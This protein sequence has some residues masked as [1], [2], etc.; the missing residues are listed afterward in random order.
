MKQIQPKTNSQA[1]PLLLQI[2]HHTILCSLLSGDTPGKVY[3][4]QPGRPSVAFGQFK[5]RAYLSGT[6]DT[7]LKAFLREFF[8]NTVTQ[9]CREA[10]V[11][12]FRLTVNDP[13]WLEIVT[14]AL[15]DLK[16][17]PVDYR[18]YRIDLDQ[19][20][21]SFTVPEGFELRETDQNLVI[22][23]FP[24]RDD[25][26]EEMCSERESVESFLAHSFGIVA[27]KEGELAGWCLSEYNHGD[28]CEVGIATM[29]PFQRLGLA[30]AMTGAFLQLAQRRGIKTVLWQCYTSNLP[31]WK[32]ALSAGF[33]LYVEDQVL[34]LYIVPE[35]NLAVHGNLELRAGNYAKALEWYHKALSGEH[36]EDWM[37]LNAARAAAQ[38][39]MTDLA[40]GFLEQAFDLG[41]DDRE[42]LM[43]NSLLAKLR[44]SPKWEDFLAKLP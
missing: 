24:G 11:P 36:H 33:H 44:T 23:D 22:S 12:F 13:R 5:H 37:P 3:L 19:P 27:F 9:N 20:Q 41:F 28:R 2:K 6:P 4:D 10:N 21:S 18:C 38:L 30:K 16:P 15:G 40:F 34:I 32:A 7:N 42:Y 25:L 26:L 29:P 39:G 17:M 8:I 1:S 14:D 35:I 43:S 31:S